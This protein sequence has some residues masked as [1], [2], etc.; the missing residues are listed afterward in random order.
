MPLVLT[1]VDA[2]T[3]RVFGGNPAAVAVVD[4]FP[5]EET[6][7]AVASE[8][9]L[10]ETAFAAPRPDGDHDLRWFTPTVEV[11]LCGH[12]TLATAHLLGGTAR[13]HTRSGLL[14]CSEGAD[15]LIEMDFPA[16][17][18]EPESVPP[19]LP[20]TDVRWFGRGR[21]DILIELGDAEA[22]RSYRPDLPGLAGLGSRAVILTAAG[23]TA[24]VDCVSRVF[25]PNA[26]IPEDPVTG[27]AHCCLAVFWQRRTGKDRLVGYQASRRGGTVHMRLSDERVVLGGHAV[28]VAEV[29]ITA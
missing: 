22:V 20:V 19:A 1:V 7:Q 5:S 16:D 17:A 14:S 29:R 2:F 4:G 13:F 12:A 3:D 6:M 21:T 26:G 25:G 28:T 11:D 10:S 9:N 24:G 15:G 27:S 18:P 8:L 23:D